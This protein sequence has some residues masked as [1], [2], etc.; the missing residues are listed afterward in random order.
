MTHELLRAGTASAGG[1][2]DSKEHLQIWKLDR[3]REMD[4]IAA[5]L[6]GV[7]IDPNECGQGQMRCRT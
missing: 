4:H 1:D 2:S 3:Y 5:G 6:R 7:T